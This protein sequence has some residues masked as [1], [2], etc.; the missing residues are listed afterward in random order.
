MFLEMSI[1]QYRGLAANQLFQ[2]YVPLF[3]GIKVNKKK[4]FFVIVNEIQTF[5]KK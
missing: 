5:D 1:G 2:K 4:I 3:K